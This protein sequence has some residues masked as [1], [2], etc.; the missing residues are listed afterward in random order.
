MDSGTSVPSPELQAATTRNSRLRPLHTCGVS[1]L[2][3]AHKVY[4]KA[5]EF[6]A[7]IGSLT[8][9]LAT[10]ASPNLCTLQYQLLAILSFTDDQILAVENVVETIF[11]P[12]A[13]VFNKID[14]LVHISETLPA[15]FDN[16]A[17]E[18]LV[19][20]RK[21]PFLN[22]A[23]TQLIWGLKILISTLTDWETDDAQ[24]KEIMIDI[25][26]DVLTKELASEDM[27]MPNSI[28]NS[29][30][31]CVTQQT[32][33][34]SAATTEKSCT[35][36]GDDIEHMKC[37][38]KEVLEEGKKENVEKKGE[39]GMEEAQ[40]GMVSKSEA[41]KEAETDANGCEGG[42]EKN[43]NAEK[44]EYGMEEAQK[45]M[46]SKSEAWKEAGT[47]GNGRE[48]GVGKNENAEKDECDKEE[49]QKAMV[50]KS[51][52]CE[53]EETDARGVMKEDPIL[54]LS[55]SGAIKPGV[56]GKF[57]PSYFLGPT[58]VSVVEAHEGKL[59]HLKERDDE[60]MVKEDSILEL[61]EAGWLR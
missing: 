13:Y 49:S 58:P 42:V 37:A 23:L 10:L 5:E 7:P 29:P 45:G 40:K 15:K 38:N 9:K 27:V 34:K 39:F 31:I 54:D 14:T 30:P 60:E 36:G 12:S 3:I 8:R 51:E 17:D 25:N 21:L 33:T 61:F 47:D 56:G 2:T 28:E 52:A 24:E 6:P 32:D 16:V 43:E 41:W 48:G 26:C 59:G 46:V 22:W 11:P 35:Q 18:F 55:E 57:A 19:I 1:I 44:G 50:S 53:G 20:I 4:A